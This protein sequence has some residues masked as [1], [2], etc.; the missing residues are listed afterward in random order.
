MENSPTLVI[1]ELILEPEKWQVEVKGTKV[2]LTKREYLFLLTLTKAGAGRVTTHETLLHI[3]Y[4]NDTMSVSARN[5]IRRHVTQTRKKLVEA[6]CTRTKI[7]A[8]YDEGYVLKI[9]T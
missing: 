8:I 3:L 5:K 4:P 2:H 9:A 1:G 7:K 6:G